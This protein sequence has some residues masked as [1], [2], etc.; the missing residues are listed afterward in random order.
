MSE[1]Q[2]NL[3]NNIVDV[4]KKHREKNQYKNMRE[5]MEEI[6]IHWRCKKNAWIKCSTKS[7]KNDKN[8]LSYCEK[9]YQAVTTK[10]QNDI[11]IKRTVLITAREQLAE[12]KVTIEEKINKKLDA[13]W[14][15]SKEK[16]NSEVSSTPLTPLS[17][18]IPLI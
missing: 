3:I 10:I 8:E 16:T 9:D 6:R 7:K 12:K 14:I 15:N 13:Q 2:E 5:S 18:L 17:T 11:E 4:C 1:A